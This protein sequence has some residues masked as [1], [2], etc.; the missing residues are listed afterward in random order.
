MGRVDT[1]DRTK[2]TA[3]KAS[4]I[5]YAE[6]PALSRAEKIDAEDLARDLVMRAEP[7]AASSWKAAMSG[8]T[9]ARNGVVAF[10]A[11][12]AWGTSGILLFIIWRAL[13]FMDAWFWLRWA[14]EK[15]EDA[16]DMY[17]EMDGFRPHIRELWERGAFELPLLG[18]SVVGLLIFVCAGPRMNQ[19]LWTPP[20]SPAP[21]DVESD[22]T[23]GY[24]VDSS[25][26]GDNGELRSMIFALSEEVSKLSKGAPTAHSPVRRRGSTSDTDHG[27]EGTSGSEEMNLA[28]MQIH[29]DRMIG[30]ASSR[31]ASPWTRRGPRGS[32]RLGA[33]ILPPPFWVA[34]SRRRLSS[35]QR[36]LGRRTVRWPGRPAPQPR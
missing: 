17:L 1:R 2:I 11:G 26:D 18:M 16:H 21:S 7:R 32:L 14:I 9:M 19:A 23:A 15:V 8:I 4:G 22:G 33:S 10:W 13:V 34:T 3:R 36:R 30:C 20:V 24:A 12:R 25:R 6:F 28:E 29:V 5:D 35:G 31:R 27:S